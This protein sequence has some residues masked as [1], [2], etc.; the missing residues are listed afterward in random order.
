V[1]QKFGLSDE[2]RQTNP[3]QIARFLNQQ[4]DQIVAASYGS[5]PLFPVH[6]Q[7]EQIRHRLHLFANWQAEW[8]RQGWEIRFTEIGSG[9]NVNFDLDDGTGITLRG[10][11]D[12]VD[13]NAA[14]NEWIIFDYKTSE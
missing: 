8:A 9:K 13:F 6:I 14:R 7:V 1:L 11:I 2:S 4:L 5:E 3:A 12:R 10:R